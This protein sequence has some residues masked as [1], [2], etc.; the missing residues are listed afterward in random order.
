[1]N[2]YLNVTTADG[3]E[4]RLSEF[5]VPFDVAVAVRESAATVITM[6]DT[7]DNPF[8]AVKVASTVRQPADPKLMELV[9]AGTGQDE[10]NAM[11]GRWSDDALRRLAAQCEAKRTATEE[12]E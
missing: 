3:P 7:A 5:S 2:V 8:K 6:L 10:K 12:D 1:M 4:I 9:D 11:V